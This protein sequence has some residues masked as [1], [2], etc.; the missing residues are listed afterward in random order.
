MFQQ[1]L[2]N[3]RIDIMSLEGNTISQLNK[4]LSTYLRDIKINEDLCYEINK[5]VNHCLFI[6][7]RNEVLDD[8]NNIEPSGTIHA[9]LQSGFECMKEV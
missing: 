4:M 3:H 2:K 9:S 1:L 6:A 8:E 7:T 5:E